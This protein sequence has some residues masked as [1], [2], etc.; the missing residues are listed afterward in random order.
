MAEYE[1]IVSQIHANILEV[2]KKLD[3][4]NTRIVVVETSLGWLKWCMSILLT[5]ASIAA[6]ALAK[7]VGF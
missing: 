5:I 6:L 4:Y 7:Y 3:E 1:K 2:S